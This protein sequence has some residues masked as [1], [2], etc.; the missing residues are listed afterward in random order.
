MGSRVGWLDE[1]DLR[2][3]DPELRALFNVN[4]P[5]DLDGR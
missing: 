5:T 4:E 2:A 3:L 1:H